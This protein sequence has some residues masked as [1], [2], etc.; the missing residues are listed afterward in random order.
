MSTLHVI[1]LA[2]GHGT[3]MKSE[4]PK[5]LHLLGGLA[6]VEHALKLAY[7][8]KPRG[9]TVVVPAEH[10]AI[11]EVLDRHQTKKIACGLA[12]Q[13]EQLGTASA[14]K[15]GLACV[16]AGTQHVVVLNADMPFVSLQSIRQLE[17]QHNRQRAVVSLL[18]A[19]VREPKG[20]GRIIRGGNGLVNAI[21]EEKD[22]TSQQRLI[23][24]INLGVYCLAVAFLN[25][26]IG[27]IKN[28]NRQ[29]EYYITDLPRIAVKQGLGVTALKVKDPLEALGVNSQ[30]HL[31]VLNHIFYQ[32]Q[33]EKFMKEGVCLLGSEIF[34][35]AGV[36]MEGGTVIES[37]CYI[38]GETQIAKNCRIETGCT[39]RGSVIAE[40][41]LIKSHTYID[42]ARVGVA[43]QVGPF[44]HLRP[45]THLSERAKVGNFVETKKTQMGFAS[46]ANHLAYLGDAEIG[47]GVN[48]GAGTIT[49]NYDGYK[50]YKTVLEDGVFIGSDTQLVAPVRVGAGAYV[51]AGT[52]VTDDVGANSLVISRVRQKEIPDWATKYRE[53][54]NSGQDQ[55]K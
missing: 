3:R 14:L 15:S 48:V 21:V 46:K 10:A 18:T 42:G 49:C 35:D 33:R 53:K 27:K 52:T 36:K 47:S 19:D 40:G 38:K 34:I 12:V 16:T 25:K 23:S 24:E 17:R 20:F 45:G 28:Q 54:N 55:K 32:Q 6:L 39:L 44:A 37:P 26:N 1:I 41:A 11:K 51:G 30:R 2:A 43:C 8:I 22:A 5:V 50:K 9:I 4:Q 13:R 29:G 7:G 31:Y